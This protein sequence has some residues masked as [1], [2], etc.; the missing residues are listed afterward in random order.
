MENIS[1]QKCFTQK[2]S[3]Q[4]PPEIFCHV[5][6]LEKYTAAFHAAGE[7]NAVDLSH[8]PVQFFRFVSHS[9]F[10]VAV[11]VVIPVC[12]EGIT[13]RIVH[14]VFSDNDAGV[15]EFES[16]RCMNTAHLMQP[17]VVDCPR[18]AS[19]ARIPRHRKIKLLQTN[20]MDL[21]IRIPVSGRC[22]WPCITGQQ[23]G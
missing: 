9:F 15:I 3:P 17:F 7:Q 2:E 11:L 12:N 22:P 21:R 23:P 8:Q 6:V 18:G 16:L 14:E 19:L 1:L 5:F 4:P 10:S 13:G 20:I